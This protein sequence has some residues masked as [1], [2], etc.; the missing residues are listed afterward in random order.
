MHL[1]SSLFE[2]PADCH[3][4]LRIVSGYVLESAQTVK[5]LFKRV[6][7]E[8]FGASTRNDLRMAEPMVVVRDQPITLALAARPRL[9]IGLAACKKQNR[10]GMSGS[11]QHA[12]AHVLDIQSGFAR[13][14]MLD[15]PSFVRFE[16]IESP[17]YGVARHQKQ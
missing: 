16:R 9:G 11:Q 17:R 12:A 4:L 7:R 5:K 15:K 10:V 2:R 1:E 3:K 8:L 14:K 6:H 13:L